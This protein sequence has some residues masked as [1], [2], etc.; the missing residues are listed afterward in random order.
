MIVGFNE[1]K[2]KYDFS[3]VVGVIHVG[4]HHGQEHEE[5]SSQFGPWT[6]THWFEPLPSAYHVLETNLS[7]KFGVKLYNCALGPEESVMSIWEDSENG[8]QSSSLMK[9]KECLQEWDH[10]TFTQSTEVQV[11]TLDSF[12]I[13]DSNMLVIDAQGYELEVLKGSVKTLESMTHV[14]CEVNLREMYEGCPS[15][16]DISNFLSQYG[17]VLRENW[18]T[19]YNW[20]DAYWSR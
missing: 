13:S 18:W 12:G 8:G 7:G 19:A 15:I 20:G 1:Y 2:H 11:R 10:I 6:S 17:F 5:Y 14:F 3:N 16:D 9:P 4:A